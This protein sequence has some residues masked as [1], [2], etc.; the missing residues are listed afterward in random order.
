MEQARRLLWMCWL[1]SI[2]HLEVPQEVRTKVTLVF[3]NDINYDIDNIRTSLGLCQQFDVV[4]EELTVEE[5]LRLMCGLRCLDKS[6]WDER[7]N[8]ALDHV[9]L[10]TWDSRTKLPK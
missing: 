7:I 10:N 8:E 6:T 2:L 3:G 5:H 1:G 9:D 4:V